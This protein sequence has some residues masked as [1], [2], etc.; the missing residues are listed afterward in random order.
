[1]LRFIQ[2][3]STKAY[4]YPKKV[5]FPYSA[6]RHFVWF[7]YLHG[8]LIGGEDDVLIFIPISLLLIDRISFFS[9]L[10]LSRCYLPFHPVFNFLLLWP[11]S[12]YLND[13]SKLFIDRNNLIFMWH[14]SVAY[15]YY[16]SFF[17]NILFLCSSS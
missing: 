10:L 7:D 15:Y 17:G 14:H 13:S 11:I 16:F 12:M 5:I 8:H 3:F 6:W 9:L 4:W 1:M 2:I